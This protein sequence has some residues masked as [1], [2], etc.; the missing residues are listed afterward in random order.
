MALPLFDR[1]QE[2]RRS[3]RGALSTQRARVAQLRAVAETEQA[4]TLV[5]LDEAQHV[6]SKVGDD[7]LA[8][9]AVAL[10]SV[11]AGVL[12]GQ[13]ARSEPYQ[14]GRG[15]A[16]IFRTPGYPILLAG[17]FRITGGEP[18]VVWARALGAVLGT[19]AVGGVIWLTTTLFSI[20]AAIVAGVMATL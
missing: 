7:A 6:L 2:E 1:K 4:T 19:L 20:R 5:R 11:E 15:Q 12:A 17:L 13:I 18:P 9:A 8:Q 16:K 3:A 14:F 10:R